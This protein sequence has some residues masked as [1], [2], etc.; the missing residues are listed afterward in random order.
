MD[1]SPPDPSVHRI[2]HA[3]T[4]ELVAISFLKGSSWPR[5]QTCVS[6]IFRGI[7]YHWATK[8]HI[9]I[10]LFIILYKYSLN[11]I[12][13]CCSVSHVWLFVIPWT[14]ACQASLSFSISGSLLKLMSIESV[15]PSN[16]FILSRSL[17]LLPSTLP[18]IKNFSNESAL[19]IK[20]PKHW[21]SASASV[22]SKNIQ[23]WFPLRLTVWFPCSPRD[24][25]VFSNITT[26]K[27]QFFGVYPSI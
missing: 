4:M 8:D 19:H 6:W 23:D 3:R 25:R 5:D 22:L 7:L 9:K 1:C 14:A 17:L 15:M 26:Q 21:A 16:H 27:H 13:C 2:F 18:S 10:L 11:V 20:W 24:L 12:F